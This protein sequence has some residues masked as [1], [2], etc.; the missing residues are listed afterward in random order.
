MPPEPIVDLTKYNLESIKY[1]ADDIRK[2]NPHRGAMALLDAVV[3]ID[4]SKGVAIGY[5]D[6]RADEFWAPGHFPG[7]S[8]L[9]GV[10]LIEAA[11]QLA[12]FF[13]KISLPEIANRLVVFG[14]VDKVRFRGSVRPGERV[15][16]VARRIEMNSRIA[17]CEAQGFSSG[18]MVFE[19]TVI[20]IPV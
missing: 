20:G 19:G 2:V 11:G 12:V 16:L 9:P 8:L 7:N 17:K 10:V 15:W 13:Y 14:G 1:T 6:A 3:D 4:E 18:K 5:K